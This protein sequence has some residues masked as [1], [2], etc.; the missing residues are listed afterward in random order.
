VEL[1]LRCAAVADLQR[2]VPDAAAG[3]KLMVLLD[4]ADT[5]RLPNSPPDLGP[6]DPH[7]GSALSYAT[8]EANA[9]GIGE[10]SATSRSGRG[11][12]GPEIARGWRRVARA[13]DPDLA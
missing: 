2:I 12:D 5:A 13:P 8:I 3:D 7:A 11:P 9:A 6:W 4:G 10:P 1:A